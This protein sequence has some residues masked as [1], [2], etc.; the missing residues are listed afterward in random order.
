MFI[1]IIDVLQILELLIELVVFIKEEEQI[2]LL[3]WTF[4]SINV[5]FLVVSKV[6]LLYGLAAESYTAAGISAYTL[7]SRNDQK[8]GISGQILKK[9]FTCW[10]LRNAKII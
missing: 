3:Q 1:V 6:S 9:P 8:C 4:L 10:C 2:S 5:F 7:S